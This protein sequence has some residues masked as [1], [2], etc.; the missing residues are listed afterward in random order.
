LAAASEELTAQA[1]SLKTI[2]G[3]LAAQVGD[4]N[5]DLN[6][7]EITKSSIEEKNYTPKKGVATRKFKPAVRIME[8]NR[9]QK[10]KSNGNGSKKGKKP[11]SGTAEE[12]IP[13]SGD[14][15]GF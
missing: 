3:E 4:I 15:T 11:L 10:A 14:F 2:V 7:S 1:E 5:V 8:N 6:D 13:L 12:L 9:A